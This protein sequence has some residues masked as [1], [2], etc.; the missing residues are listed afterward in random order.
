MNT[1]QMSVPGVYILS[2]DDV[3][4]REH[5]RQKII[6]KIKD[7]HG[8]I[9]LQKYDSSSEGFDNFL[10]RILTPSLFEETRIFQ[11]SHAQNL[12]DSDIKELDFLLDSPPPDSCII[13]EI[14]EEKSG[15]TTASRINKK[16]NLAKKVKNGKCTHLKFPKP[17]DYQTAAWLME[18]V[19]QLFERKITKQ[20]AEYLVELIGS[21]IG[22]LYSEL[23]KIDINLPPGKPVNHAC[24]KEIVGASR[25]MSVFELS[26][27]LAQKDLAK[28]LTIVDS[29]FST[30]FYGPVMVSA[31]FKKF[32][33]LFRIKRY[34]ASNPD[35]I[36]RFLNSKGYK[37]PVQTETG[38]AIGLASGLLSEGE[39]NKIY[40]IM[41]LSGVVEQSKNFS[42]KELSMILKWLLQFDV[43]IKTGRI[44]GTQQDIQMFCYKIIRV[45]ELLQDDI[46]A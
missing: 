11:I 5:A 25:Q 4:G 41:I 24:I 18:K 36:K 22:L 43:A 16:L 44:S 9:V 23:Q 10:Q 31:L 28:T 21:D 19:P 1:T 46:A 39:Q 42:E 34:D 40:P 8:Q 30:G 3:V 32:W 12:S 15:K 38:Y 7:S 14:D 45:S 13:I 33:A 37:N 2:G 27:A 20:D 35:V 6:Q 17:P 29:I 26:A